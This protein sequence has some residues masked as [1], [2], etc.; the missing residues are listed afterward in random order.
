MKKII[1]QL[2]C[3]LKLFS[4]ESFEDKFDKHLLECTTNNGWSCAEIGMTYFREQNIQK[5]KD[6]FDKSCNLGTNAGCNMLA[7]IEFSN[8]NYK[9]SIELFDKTCKNN[10]S[11]GCLNMGIIYKNGYGVDIDNQKALEFFIKSCKLRNNYAC[12]MINAGM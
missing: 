12:E 4:N 9:K 8:E 3:V 5:A 7:H 11:Y 2:L 6:F 10:S 1:F